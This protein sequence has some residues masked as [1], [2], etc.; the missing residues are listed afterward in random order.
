MNTKLNFDIEKLKNSPNHKFKINELMKFL[1]CYFNN[2]RPKEFIKYENEL[3]TLVNELMF[4]M[5]F[6]ELLNVIPNYYQFCYTV[7]IEDNSLLNQ[8]KISEHLLVPFSKM[9]KKT[10]N[11]L[12]FKPLFYDVFEDRYVIIC[13]HAVTTGMYA[14]GPAIYSIITGLLD[15]GKTIVL[16]TIGNVDHQ[17]IKLQKN[18]S[19]LTI[20]KKDDV[21]T[22]FIQLINLRKICQNF[23]PTKIITEMPVN[24]GTALYYSKI[25]SKVLYWSPG[26]T[27]VPW[28]DKVLLVPELVNKKLLKTSKFIEVPRSL[29]FEL[30]NPNVNH[31][32]VKRFKQEKLFLESDFVM[33]TFARY[34]LISEAFLELVFNLL[35]I[36]KNRKIII[37]GTNDSS[38]AKKKL[39]KFID[40][41]QAIILGFSDV[42]ILGNCCD[43]FLDTIPYPCGF[44]AIEVMAKG[45]PVLSINQPNLSNYKKSR[46]NKLIFEN[47]EDL[48]ECL[49][50]L[51]NNSKFYN[52]MSEKSI[53]IAKDYDNSLKLAETIASL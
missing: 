7:S 49:I 46:V 20:L 30:I 1:E 36:N 4:E 9:L 15:L 33:G 25:T 29:N 51:E 19:R 22:S 2:G 48:N 42:H 12:N 32:L 17:F 10:L 16:V 37:A 31:K 27:H 41:K 14:P 23:R 47:E 6:E 40:N 28:F 38:K 39:K 11:Q 35:K 18:N 26:F 13:R 43:V 52:E 24:I 8:S 44:S 21:S 34:E 50:K 5:S 3:K 53:K 45:K